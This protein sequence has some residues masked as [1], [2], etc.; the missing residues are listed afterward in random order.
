MRII[1]FHTHAFPDN[2]AENAIPYLEQ[3]AEVKAFHD[4]KLSSLLSCM[5]MA[6]IEKAVVCSIATKPTQ[7][8]SILEWSG[9]IAS[10]RI[11][12]FPSVHPDDENM[13]GKVELIARS[14]FK[15][16]KIHPY[17]QKFSIDERRML[18]FYEAVAANGLIL[19]CHTGFDLAFPYDRIADPQKTAEVLRR[20][21]GL[22]FV[23]S[24]FGA[25]QDW[26]EVE[27]YLL[28]RPVYM[29]ISYSLDYLSA[30]KAEHFFRNHPLD[31][32]LFG[33]DSPW[34]DQR[35]ALSNLKA[36]H[37]EH[38]A[39]VKILFSNAARLLGID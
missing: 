27:K 25:W 19:L 3:E 23:T 2:V 1:D 14:G 30:A 5:D 17:Y 39:E 32:I 10:D 26:E 35:R 28:G 36:V 37:L 24:H 20:F 11:I 38:E 8:K 34:D 18:P 22:K 33:S 12:P 7:F 13:V 6:E 9:T 31:Y 29:D 16:I 4:G 15:G 21:P